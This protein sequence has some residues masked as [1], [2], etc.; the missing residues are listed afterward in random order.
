MS[1]SVGRS[2]VLVID[3]SLSGPPLSVCIGDGR[4]LGQDLCQVPVEQVG[5]VGERLG[6]QRVIVH[7]DGAGVAETSS[8]PAGHEVDD[9]RV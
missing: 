4:V 7:H 1:V 2:V 8:E 6:V 9:P 3:G 5:V